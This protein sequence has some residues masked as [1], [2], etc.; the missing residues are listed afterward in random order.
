MRVVLREK[1]IQGEK[2]ILIIFYS[3][4]LNYELLL[5]A[6]ELETLIRLVHYPIYTYALYL[7]IILD[8][9]FTYEGLCI[10]SLSP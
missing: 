6:D 4:K 8:S 10:P 3:L 9:K 7:C 1:L 5:K 2:T